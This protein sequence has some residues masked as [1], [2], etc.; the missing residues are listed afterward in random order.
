M[1]HKN[2]HRQLM[3]QSMYYYACS[4]KSMCTYT[5]M[6]YPIMANLVLV[7]PC[8]RIGVECQ[9]QSVNSIWEIPNWYG[10]ESDSY[11]EILVISMHV[12]RGGV[13]IVKSSGCTGIRLAKH[14]DL[15]DELECCTIVYRFCAGLI[16]K[17]Q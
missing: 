15:I 7:M 2:V 12:E 9:L 6:Y 4:E 16:H 1:K 8:T 13:F 14:V 11:T 5:Y 10:D 3:Q 17:D